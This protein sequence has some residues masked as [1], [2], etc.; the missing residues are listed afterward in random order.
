MG[1][2]SLFGGCGKVNIE[3]QRERERQGGF[4]ENVQHQRQGRGE[5][6]FPTRTGFIGMKIRP[7]AG[8]LNIP[9]GKGKKGSVKDGRH[10]KLQR[11]QGRKSVRELRVRISKD[12]KSPHRSEKRESRR[13]RRTCVC[14]GVGHVKNVF[15]ASKAENRGGYTC[16]KKRYRG[17]WF[18]GQ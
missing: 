7:L 10:N 13:S 3:Y 4:R 17:K 5:R 16:F 9:S 1:S 15:C 6:S 11:R 18:A 2:R 12:T 8:H 14:R